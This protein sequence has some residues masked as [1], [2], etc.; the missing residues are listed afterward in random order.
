MKGKMEHHKTF[1]N[2]NKNLLVENSNKN[3]LVLKI[4]FGLC[5]QIW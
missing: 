5:V 1:E 4:F 2:N 3:L